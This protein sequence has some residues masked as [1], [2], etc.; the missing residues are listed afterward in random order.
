MPIFRRNSYV[1]RVLNFYSIYRIL[2]YSVWDA[3]LTAFKAA[4]R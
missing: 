1:M 3:V 4:R 2:D